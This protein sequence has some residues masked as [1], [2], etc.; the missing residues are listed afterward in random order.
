MDR[1]SLTVVDLKR[2]LKVRLKEGAAAVEA[3]PVAFAKTRLIAIAGQFDPAIASHVDH[4]QSL[5]GASLPDS[6]RQ[7]LAPLFKQILFGRQ[8]FIDHQAAQTIEKL[9]SGWSARWDYD[10]FKWLDHL[11]NDVNDRAVCNLISQMTRR[12]ERPSPP[13]RP[14]RV[15]HQPGCQNIAGVLFGMT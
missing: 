8:G 7:R 14:C 10:T 13:M 4:T 6:R 5:N 15:G 2:D 12:C 1:E 11:R 3:Q 9:G